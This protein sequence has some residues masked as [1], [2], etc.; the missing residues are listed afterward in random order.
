MPTKKFNPVKLG[1][2][3][4]RA[5]DKGLIYVLYG[6]GSEVHK[7]IGYVRHYRF[8]SEKYWLAHRGIYHKAG[9]GRTDTMVFKGQIPSNSFAKQLFKNIF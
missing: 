9:G 5:E 1:L 6:M 2:Y 4:T 7:I 3:R 8:G